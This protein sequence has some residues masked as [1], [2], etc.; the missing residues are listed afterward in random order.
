[1]QLLQVC[2]SK[3]CLRTYNTDRVEWKNE[4]LPVEL[5]ERTVRRAKAPEKYIDQTQRKKLNERIYT[6]GRLVR[7]EQEY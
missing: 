7:E 2:I 5:K 6:E 3:E 4:Q 1:M